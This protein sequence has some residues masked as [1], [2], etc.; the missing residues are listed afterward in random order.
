MD[1]LIN[2]PTGT[3]LTE[4]GLKKLET[5]LAYL[6]NE[7]RVEVA[8]LLSNAREFGDIDENAE[9][10]SAKDEQARLESE[11]AELEKAIRSGIV[12]DKASINAEQVNITTIVSVR[13]EDDGTSEEYTIVGDN[14][15]DPSN[16][17]ISKDSPI[18][19]ALF[20]KRKGDLVRADTPGGILR[21]RILDIRK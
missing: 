7:K 6:K 1:K 11:I 5:R 17:V 10:D 13:Y 4:D 20:G 15:S 18:G 12:I 19:S 3:I 16:N 21:M 2:R 14:E 8:E 9:L